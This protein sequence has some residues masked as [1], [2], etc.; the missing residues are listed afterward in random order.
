MERDRQRV[1]GSEGQRE[2]KREQLE[3]GQ[4]NRETHKNNIEGMIKSMHCQVL[5]LRD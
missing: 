1:R 3:M 2:S 5:S 4:R